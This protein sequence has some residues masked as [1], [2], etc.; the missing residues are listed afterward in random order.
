MSQRTLQ[1]YGVLR[2]SLFAGGNE[3]CH[4]LQK[5]N[6][7]ACNKDSSPPCAHLLLLCS[8]TRRHPPQHCKSCLRPCN[9]LKEGDGAALFSTIWLID[10]RAHRLQRIDLEDAH[11]SGRDIS[12]F[13]KLVLFRLC[14]RALTCSP[15]SRSSLSKWGDDSGTW[16][17]A[18]RPATP[19]TSYLLVSCEV[20]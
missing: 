13:K 17:T 3:S 6:I 9:D 19:N 12:N 4:V 10:D 18:I 20:L 15:P 1:L 8:T 11:R 14:V 7:I 5:M 2:R 16:T